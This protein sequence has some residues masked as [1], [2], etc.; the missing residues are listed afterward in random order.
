MT[1]AHPPQPL[2]FARLACVVATG[3]R[4]ELT[5]GK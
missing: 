1:S 2:P 3:A 5:T 4:V